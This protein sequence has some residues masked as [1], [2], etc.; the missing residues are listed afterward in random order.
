LL[1]KL[2][3]NGEG[4]AVDSWV[5]TGE[6]KSVS[7]EKVKRALGDKQVGRIASQLGV[8]EDQAAGAVAQVL[9]DVVDEVAPKG[10]LPDRKGID[11]ELKRSDPGRRKRVRRRRG[12]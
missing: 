2:K 10:K 3:E 11:A 7:K 9:P 1:G 12:R 6:N 4:E 8:S 5:G